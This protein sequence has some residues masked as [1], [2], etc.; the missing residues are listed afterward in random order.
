M[1]EKLQSI[2]GEE[3]DVAVYLDLAKKELM[4]W[5]YGRELEEFP[6]I[7]EPT[8][9]MAVVTAFGMEGAEGQDSQTVDGV[10][11]DFHYTDMID[12]IHRNTPGYAKLL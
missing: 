2:L 12:Y 9:I 5:M 8:C 1:E 4:Y 6:V 11:H 7:L 10:K 3:V